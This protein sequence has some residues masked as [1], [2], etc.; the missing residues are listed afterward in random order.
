MSLH[1]IVWLLC[2]RR[3][4]TMTLDHIDGDVTNNHIENLR[5]CTYSDNNLN[6]Q[7]PWKPNAKTGVPGV[8]IRGKKYRSTI[9]GKH[10]LFY[11]PFEAFYIATLCGKRYK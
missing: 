7:L 6:M 5:E 10:S 2:K 1:H 11:S 9:R 8:D 4:P 3:W